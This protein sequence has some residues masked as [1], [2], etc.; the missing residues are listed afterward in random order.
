MKI[1]LAKRT[2]RPSRRPIVL[3]NI[4]PSQAQAGNLLVIYLKVIAAWR[5][6][7]A[8]I[9]AEYERT[10]SRLQTDS[11]SDTTAAIDD[12][13]AQIRRLVLELTPELKRWALQVERVHQGRWVGNIMSATSVDLSTVLSASDMEDTIEAS[14]NWNTALIRDVSDETRRR[15]ANSVFAGFQRRAAAAEIA[16]EISESISMARARARRIAADQTV[17]LGSRLN[18]ARQEQAG[19]THFKWRHSGKAHPRSWHLARNGQIYPWAR[20]GIPA[21]DMPGV[22][23]FCGCTAQGVITFEDE[24]EQVA[25]QREP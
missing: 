15:I 5:E 24:E 22:P 1:D 25:L 8:A 6:G 16:K 20:S 10:L 3:P 21:S 7:A 9:V 14:L 17:K 18:E 11:P 23:P 2:K 19:L 13:D 12:L 4:A